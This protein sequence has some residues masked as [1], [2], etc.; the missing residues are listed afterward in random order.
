[1]SVQSRPRTAA[2]GCGTGG[3]SCPHIAYMPARRPPYA[4]RSLTGTDARMAAPIP[5]GRNVFGHRPKEARHVPQCR[6]RSRRQPAGRDAISLAVALAEPTRSLTLVACSTGAPARPGAR[7]SRRFTP[8]CA[9]SRS[10]ARA[11]GDGGRRNADLVCSPT[12]RARSAGACTR[13]PNS[14]ARPA[15]GRLV[16]SAAVR[17]RAHRRRHQARRSTAPPARSRRSARA[18]VARAAGGFLGSASA[19]TSRPRARR[20]SPP[21]ASVAA[22]IGAASRAPCRPDASGPTVTTMPANWGEILEQDR[23][24]RRRAA[25][26]ARS[27]TSRPLPSTAIAV[28]E[29]AAFGDRVD[30]LVVGSR[31]YGPVRR[32][33]LGSTS[34]ELARDARCAL[35]VL[36]RAS[37]ARRTPRPSTNGRATVRPP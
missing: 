31:G 2:L 25:P 6:D 28:E 21:P 33:V 4:S 16:P 15:R 1:M 7:R 30:L 23:A 12:A 20:R 29:L 24:R 13:S 17:P 22:R 3:Q 34:G 19:T 32:L 11:R 37:D 9:T 36:P 5:A 10:A 14:A 27:G 26:A 35:L 8:P 18:I